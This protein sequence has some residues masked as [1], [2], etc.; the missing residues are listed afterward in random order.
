MLNI[1]KSAKTKVKKRSKELQNKKKTITKIEKKAIKF[2]K[3]YFSSFKLVERYIEHRTKRVKKKFQANLLTNRKKKSIRKISFKAFF[4]LH[5]V[6]K[7]AENETKN[8]TKIFKKLFD[9]Q[10]RFYNL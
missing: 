2:T 5:K 9:E 10:Q 6:A 1:N 8:E 3:R 7:F 4:E